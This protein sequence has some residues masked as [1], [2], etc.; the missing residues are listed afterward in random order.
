V[1]ARSGEKWMRLRHSYAVW[2]DSQHI[3]V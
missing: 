1:T 2:L 3:L